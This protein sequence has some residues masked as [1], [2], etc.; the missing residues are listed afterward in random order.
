[1]LPQD[2]EFIGTCAHVGETQEKDACGRRRVAWLYSMAAEGVRAKVAMI[3][4][5]QVGFLYVVPIEISPWGP[6]GEDLLVIPCMYVSPSETKQ[7]IGHLL[8][9]AAEAEALAQDRKGITAMACNHEAWFMPRT[10]FEGLGFEVADRRGMEL[11]L[12]KPS[13]QD[14]QPPRL[15][16]ASY[17]FK[18]TRGKVVVD[19][20]WNRFC[21]TS[22]IEAERVRAVTGE[23]G[24]AVELCEHDS[25]DPAVLREYQIPRAIFVQGEQVTWGYEAPRDGLREAIQRAR[26]DL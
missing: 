14:A 25:S 16:G 15:L 3:G 1:M 22:E 8:V 13:A 17:R 24:D 20:F 21:L 26:V 12:W 18:P 23:F 9:A 11:V 10:F 2:E 19:L 4:D 5:R 7:G 6:I